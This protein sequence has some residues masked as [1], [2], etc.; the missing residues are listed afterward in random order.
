[1]MI[2]YVV[3]RNSM[4]RKYSNKDWKNDLRG[5]DWNWRKKR[6]RYWSLGGLPGGTEMQEGGI[7]PDILDFLD[8]T[9]YCGV[10]GKMQFFRCKVK[11]SKK[12]FRSKIKA[13]KEW[14][15]V[16]RTMPMEKLFKTIN[17]KLRGHYQYYGVS[18]N[19]KEVKNFLAWTK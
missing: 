10:D 19:S 18:N 8:F 12:K 16:H 13:I 15:K 14:I 17:A 6:R 4:K 3:F 1:M 11:T 7:K 5:M 2:L 9:F